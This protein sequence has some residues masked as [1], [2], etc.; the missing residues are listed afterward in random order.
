MGCIKIIVNWLKSD[1]FTNECFSFCLDQFE[2]GFK[3]HKAG[4][5][6]R[7]I[8]IRGQLLSSPWLYMELWRHSA[9]KR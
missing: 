4:C 8:K 1:K 9:G 3:P 2:R 6:E 7:E 5:K